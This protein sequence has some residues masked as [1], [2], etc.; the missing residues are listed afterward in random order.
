MLERRVSRNIGTH[1]AILEQSWVNR[2][3]YIGPIGDIDIISI[4]SILAFQMSVF[5][6]KL[7]LY[8]WQ[9]NISNFGYFITLFAIVL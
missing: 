9:L 7:I 8:Q 2:Q 3:R 4:V 6:I 1:T 5:Q